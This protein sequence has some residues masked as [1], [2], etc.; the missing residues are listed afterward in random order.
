MHFQIYLPGV[1]GADPEHLVRVGLE[2]LTLR[3]QFLDVID[4][5]GDR[6]GMLVGW[7][8]GRTRSIGYHPDRQTWRPAVANGELAAG[9]YWVGFWNDSPPRPDDLARDYPYPGTH[10]RFGDGRSWLLPRACQLPNDM[11]RADDGSWRFEVQRRFHRFW[12]DSIS[13][14]ARLMAMQEGDTVSLAEMA[15]FV[16]Q[17]LLINYRMTP[18]VVNYLRL[19]TTGETGTVATALNAL[20]EI[21]R[22]AAPAGGAA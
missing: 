12:M 5:P 19:F 6:G 20:M 22:P 8:G 11:I 1:Q 4:G 14:H 16:E 2:T 3:A 15:E 18:E 17:A 9:R 21:V 10:V 7:L 13:W